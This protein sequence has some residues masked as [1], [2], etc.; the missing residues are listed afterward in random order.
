MKDIKILINLIGFVGVGFLVYAGNLSN[1]F[2]FNPKSP[3]AETGQVIPF[4]PKSSTVYI[5]ESDVN[6]YHFFLYGS[7]V[8]LGLYIPLYFLFKKKIKVHK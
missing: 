4:V 2:V 5:T 8:L 3:A 6:T 1:S 7:F